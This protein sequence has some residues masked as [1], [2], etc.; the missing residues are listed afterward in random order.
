MAELQELATLVRR[1][2]IGWAKARES[3]DDYFLDGVQDILQV[4]RAVPHR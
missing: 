2:E 3:Q 4:E 1:A